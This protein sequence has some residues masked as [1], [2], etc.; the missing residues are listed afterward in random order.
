MSRPLRLNAPTESLEYERNL[1]RDVVA[2]GQVHDEAAAGM[3]V[4]ADR[5][6]AELDDRSSRLA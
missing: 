1:L 6:D 2:K 5:I 4:W 3:A